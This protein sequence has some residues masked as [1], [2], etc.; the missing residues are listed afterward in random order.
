MGEA[1]EAGALAG[2]L[3]DGAGAV[4]VDALG[5]VALD[6]GEVDRG[7][8]VDGGDLVGERAVLAAG[9]A[10]VHVADVAFEHGGAAPDVAG[11]DAR[12][13][14]VEGDAELGAH[15]EVELAAGLGLE[16]LAD[17][18][19]G[20]EGGEAGDERGVG[21]GF[22]HGL[23]FLSSGFFGPPARRSRHTASTWRRVAS[24]EPA[25]SIA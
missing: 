8:V 3:E 6:A 2:Q 10:E 17:H 1:A 11:V 19:A 13:E 14:L 12:E 5:D 7:E 23:P 9:E 25:L 21:G 16:D 24:G 15:E 20:G 22:A 18:P 4:D